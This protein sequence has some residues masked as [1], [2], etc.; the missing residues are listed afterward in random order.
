MEKV[1]NHIIFIPYP[2]ELLTTCF[3]KKPK[4]DAEFPQIKTYEIVLR[5]PP[6]PGV[7]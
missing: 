2:F 6:T 7:I 4:P 1:Q 3:H 5:E